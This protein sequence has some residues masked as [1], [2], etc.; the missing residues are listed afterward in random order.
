MSGAP[1]PDLLRLDHRRRDRRPCGLLVARLGGI[2]TVPSQAAAMTAGHYGL[3]NEPVPVDLG[4]FPSEIAWHPR[5]R[6][7]AGHI[8]L[9]GLITEIV[10]GLNL[11]G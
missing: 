4:T 10:A 8:W 7:D 3:R 5:L 9:R 11:G 2:A 1:D 6:R